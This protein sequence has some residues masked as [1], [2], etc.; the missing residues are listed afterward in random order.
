MRV[1]K[2]RTGMVLGPNGGALKQMLTPFRAGVGGRLGDGRQWMPWIH[3]DDIAEIFRHAIEGTAVG[4]L[5]GVAPGQVTNA[6]FTAAL[7]KALHRPTVLPVPRF[8]LKLM[9]GEMADMLLSSQRVVPRATEK[10]GYRFQYPELD[11][12]LESIIRPSLD[13]L[14]VDQHLERA[15]VRFVETGFPGR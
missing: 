2:V 4:P 12:A 11:A 13:F 15:I 1:V 7:G 9:F 3:I 10:A 14:C 8:A 6:Q 5:N